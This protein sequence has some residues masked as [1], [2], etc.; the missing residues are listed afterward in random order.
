MTWSSGRSSI[1]SELA[2][3]D[4]GGRDALERVVRI[5]QVLEA[6][7][8]LG[9]VGGGPARPRPKRVQV[10]MHIEVAQRGRRAVDVADP[11]PPRQDAGGLVERGGDAVADLL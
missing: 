9:R 3:A 8:L 11:L 4:A 7:A 6:L 5:A 1:T 2:A 10:L